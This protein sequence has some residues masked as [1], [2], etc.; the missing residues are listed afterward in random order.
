VSDTA[1]A[2]R[3]RVGPVAVIAG[4]DHPAHLRGIALAPFRGLAAEPEVLVDGPLCLA[5][6]PSPI[7]GVHASEQ[8]ICLLTGRT[9]DLGG[10]AA[11]T[12]DGPAEQIVATGWQRLGDAA[13]LEL[14]G[15]FW[16]LLWDRERRRGIV[17]CDQMGGFCPTWAVSAGDVVVASELPEVVAALPRRPGPDPVA[18]AHW[19]VLTEPP[20]GR[21]LFEGVRRLEAGHL[22]EIGP[23]AAAP[24]R[25]EPRRYWIPPLRPLLDGSRQDLVVEVRAALERSLTRRLARASAPSVLLSGGLDSSVVAC[26][27]ARLVAGGTNGSGE[28]S[29]LRSYSATFPDHPAVDESKLID[30]TVAHLG[31]P[32]TRIVVTGGSLVL[33]SVLPYLS[34]W[35]TPPTSPNLFFWTPLLQRAGVDGIDVMLDGEGGDELFGFSAY[36]VTD[37]LLRGRL[38]SAMQLA[39]RAPGAPRTASQ[40]LHVLRRIGLG[41][42]MPAGT[43]AARWAHGLG[44]T[45]AS[46]M[47]PGAARLWHDTMLASPWK[48]I[49]G[50]RWWAWLVQ[51]VTRGVG[52]A[53]VYEQSRRRAAMAGIEARHPLVDVDV[54]ELVLR[55][56][57]ELAF[58]SRWS[59]PIL[60]ESVAGLLPDEVRLHRR[61]SSFDAVFHA[62]LAG[63]DLQLV[64]RI[65]GSPGAEVGA[66]VDLEAVRR[67]LLDRDP[68]LDGGPLQQWALAVWRLLTAECWLRAEADPDFSA[69][70]VGLAGGGRPTFEGHLAATDQRGQWQV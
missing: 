67:Q 15:D 48:S 9:Y 55:L 14:R 1:P 43:R 17:A 25:N 41:G 2:H 32:A 21:L 35:R 45:P 53:L 58:D 23:G 40:I 24:G 47:R 60:R 5:W 6:M 16:V 66:Y 7:C 44:P 13:L 61:K 63:P 28:R 30:R 68:P 65:L 12:T 56:P 38:L 27:A 42:A 62:I 20:G 26:L 8:G 50:P 3:W 18:M 19:L 33:G 59:R 52:P 39:T 10:L 34:T 46:W 11:N 54:I 69:G 31:L 37:R 4:D 36:L 70:L 29:P 57:P 51:G 64:R 22:L 49:R